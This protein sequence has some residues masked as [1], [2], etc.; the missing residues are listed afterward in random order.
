M[1]IQHFFD[2]RT[3][4]LTYVVHNEAAKA[5]VVIDAV[6]DF[7]PKN[8]RTWNESCAAVTRYIEDHGLNIRYMLDTHAHAD[9]LSGMAYFKRVYGAPTVIGVHI[10]G[11]GRETAMCATKRTV[12]INEPSQGSSFTGSA[13]EPVSR[14]NVA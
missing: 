13:K 6:M 12:G 11:N 7:D 9:H 10:R 5:D 14:W 3:S 8:G 4:T 2:T 1:K